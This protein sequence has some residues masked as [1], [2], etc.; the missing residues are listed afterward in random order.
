M[1]D[2]DII[3][4]RGEYMGDGVPRTF[5]G[6]PFE[7]LSWSK[8]KSSG[9]GLALSRSAVRSVSDFS[10]L[11]QTLSPKT[12][13]NTKTS[14][15]SQTFRDIDEK[16]KKKSKGAVSYDGLPAVEAE[17]I[18]PEW[19]EVDGTRW[20][21]KRGVTMLV[22]ARRSGKS[23]LTLYLAA[24]VS[25]TC[26]NVLIAAQEDDF[27]I[28]K[29]R[30]QSMDADMTRIHFFTKK[31]TVDVWDD[32]SK[33]SAEV[34]AIFDYRDIGG[35]ER[36]A[37]RAEAELI[38]IDPITSLAKGDWNRQDS[39]SCLA[40][41]NQWAQDHSAAVL[42]VMHPHQNPKDVNTAA[43]GTS[44][45]I[46]Q[47]RSHLAMASVPGD[48]FHAV[49]QQVT[50][51]YEGT[52]NRLVSFATKEMADVHNV[53]FTVRYVTGME[54]TGQTVQEIYD[55]DAQN[56]A[57][58]TDPDMKGDIAV[59]LHDTIKESG[60]HVFATDLQKKAKD[61]KGWT[62]ANLRSAY[63]VARV[64]ST[65][66]SCVRPRSILYLADLEEYSSSDKAKGLTPEQLAKQW[67]GNGSQRNS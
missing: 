35:I 37:E 54:P 13:G 42:A 39:A 64:S 28:L 19:L 59:W 52:C 43:T 25:K 12:V 16:S 41:L 24:R 50:Q 55:L 45:W 8:D 33:R 65:K 57:T 51:S 47:A 62:A 61:V 46:D 63:D 60:C 22:G 23:T 38:V 44:Q 34:R 20:L 4:D 49:V 7:P 29:A 11:I 32:D 10:D 36:V 27:G 30:L 40:V 48:S 17:I 53:P 3:V 14:Q 1:A 5:G 67:G 31:R 21:V 66:Q 2:S 56:L 58:P 6:E 9:C 18:A 26:G 15:T